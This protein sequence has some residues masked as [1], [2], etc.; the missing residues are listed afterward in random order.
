MT[1][2]TRHRAA[3]S[4][5]RRDFL[6]LTTAAAATSLIGTSRAMAQSGTVSYWHHFAS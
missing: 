5:K 4:M 3:G 6:A 2:P 1:H